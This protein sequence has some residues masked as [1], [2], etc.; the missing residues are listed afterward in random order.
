MMNKFL[1]IIAGLILST[2]AVFAQN[3][4]PE[5]PQPARLVND[6]T[7]ILT[8]GEKDFLEKKLVYFSDSTGTQI[9]V[10]IVKS[11]EFYDRAE[12]TYLIHK[13]W[14]VGQQGKDNG[15]VIMVKPK[16]GQERGEAFIGTGKG[17][18]GVIPD[19][20]AK[21]IIENEM[22]PYFKQ[23]NYFEGLDNAINTVMALANKEFTAAD[24][25][26]N[27]TPH[28]A[29]A[30][31]PLLVIIFIFILMMVRAKRENASLGKD[32]SFLTLLLLMSASNRRHS[33]S[34]GDFSGGGGGRG[35]G[36]FGG[37]GG[38]S[39]GGGGAGGSW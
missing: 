7:N 33:G 17:L 9:A 28:P 39:S 6:Y 13:N 36:G 4:I 2:S 32:T 8:P 23:N 30:L 21:N 16:I 37:F 35:G 14:Q 5:R 20:T 10:V 11:L 15:I 19:V 18:E 25:D 22:I 3:G 38:G 34:F 29:T 1:I 26:K 12:F 27:N 24:Y 31:I